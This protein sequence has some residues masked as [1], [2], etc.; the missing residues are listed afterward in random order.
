M[1]MCRPVL[2]ALEE[3]PH[4]PAEGWREYSR[5]AASR[6]EP[7]R[8]RATRIPGLVL[9][10]VRSASAFAGWADERAMRQLREGA[11]GPE[12][13]PVFWGDDFHDGQAD[14][15]EVQS[16]ALPL[17]ATSPADHAGSGVAVAVLDSGI[18]ARHPFLTVHESASTCP[19]P[20]GVPSRHGTHCAGII[21]SR[22]PDHPGIAP[23]V[24]LIDVKV[25]RADGATSPGW[26]AKGIDAALDLGA[27]VLSISFGLNS[28]PAGL[29]NGHGWE[30]AEGRCVLCR[31]AQRAVACGAVVVAAA[32]N[33]H[34]RVRALRARGVDI[35][36]GDELLCP[37]RARAAL[38]VGAL[39]GQADG[40]LYPASSRGPR[41]SGKPELAAPG[42]E[43]VSTIP[44]AGGESASRSDLFGPASGTSASTAI[45][46]GW[47]A[48]LI[49]RRRAS[50]L[51]CSPGCIRREILHSATTFR[52]DEHGYEMSR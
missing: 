46:A 11:L 20:K 16:L 31:A 50:S 45:V 47:V 6:L 40:R 48:L 1:S 19:E 42:V 23:S 5:R 29:P 9:D 52:G 33:Q 49:E 24:R 13:S 18:D 51:S 43:V 38:T 15:G 27:D 35:D 8:R 30:C 25:A 4:R 21:A 28:L 22:S 26:L 3:I 32:G 12:L 7:A 14:N 34:L 41:G 36:D 10:P 17:R 37:G 44:L 39:G 2:L